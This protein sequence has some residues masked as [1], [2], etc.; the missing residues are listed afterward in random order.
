MTVAPLDAYTHVLPRPY[1]EALL[2][3]GPDRA[4]L[5]RWLELD[6]LHD[7]DARL[8]VMSQ[9]EGY[10]Q[11]LTLS[12][13]PIEAVAEGPD[14]L[15]LARTAND[16]M[17]AL[18]ARHPDAFPCFVCSLP[19]S[20]PEAAAAEAERAIGELGAV[21][22]QMFTNVAGHPLDEERFLPLFERV[23]ALERPIWLHPARG[24]GASDYPVEAASRY[25]I[26]WALGW[27]YETTA[28]MARLV[29]SGLLDRFPGLAIVTHHMGGLAPFL[30]GRLALGWDQLG[31]RTGSAEYDDH[32]A[33]LERR[34]IDYFRGFYADTALFGSR[35]ATRLGLSFFGAERCLF[36]TDFPFDP[37]GGAILIRET[38]AAIDALDLSEDERRAILCGNT[39]LLLDLEVAV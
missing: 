11:V 3:L 12:S 34:P 4:L 21:G 7:I 18:C 10:R 29:F 9:F 2:D 22:V 19:M 5:R 6:V 35:E 24:P 13:P 16:A 38:L 30:E 27:P 26:W 39:Q 32:L 14:A 33:R 1:L 31:S 23:S 20:D 37:E 8:R 25:E 36:A 28:A 15:R 17:A